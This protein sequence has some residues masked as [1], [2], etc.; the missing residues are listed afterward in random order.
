[1]EAA[2]SCFPSTWLTF[3]RTGTASS[4]RRWYLRTTIK[5]RRRSY[6]YDSHASTRSNDKARLA[7]RKAVDPFGGLRMYVAEND[8]GT[9]ERGNGNRNHDSG[10]FAPAAT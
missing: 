4:T 3:G 9:G 5:R 8:F 7:L 1:M 10:G 2:A 6:H